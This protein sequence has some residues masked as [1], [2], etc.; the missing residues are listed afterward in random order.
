MAIVAWRNA[1]QMASCTIPGENGQPY[2]ISLR[3]GDMAAK[4]CFLSETA[5]SLSSKS[6]RA[7]C[8]CLLFLPSA[9]WGAGG[10]VPVG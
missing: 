9:E 3:I 7:M 8:Y 1:G 10:S 2:G 6:V 4:L 5:G